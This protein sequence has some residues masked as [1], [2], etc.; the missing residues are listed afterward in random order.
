LRGEAHEVCAAADQDTERCIELPRLLDRG[1]HE[2]PSGHQTD[3]A[4]DHDAR[5]IPIHQSAGDRAQG[6]GDEKAE[7]EG[8][9]N[10]T[11]IPP[12][13]IDKRRQQQRECR[14]RGH[15]DRHR[16][17]RDADD[18]PPVV[19][20]QTRRPPMGRAH[21]R[22]LSGLGVDDVEGYFPP[23][24]PLDVVCNQLGPRIEHALS[25]T[26]YVR[27]HDDVAEL[28]KWLR[29]RQRRFG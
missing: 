2:K 27:G 5:A 3:T 29:R 25:P 22:V 24:R 23:C 10:E 4:S 1:C 12:E 16:H 8:A 15:T 28:V 26:G 18:Q 21:Y 7:R 14:A 19:E 11:S 9:G 13:L 20:R 6:C 17:E